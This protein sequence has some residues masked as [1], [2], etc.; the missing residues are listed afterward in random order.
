MQNAK[1]FG[2]LQRIRQAELLYIPLLT[3][4]PPPAAVTASSHARHLDRWPEPIGPDW[5]PGARG[6]IDRPCREKLPEVSRP[7]EL[8]CSSKASSD[9]I[10]PRTPEKAPL[11]PASGCMVAAPPWRR[12]NEIN[13]PVTLAQPTC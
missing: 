2:R 5:L 8:F 12:A 11:Q 3:H 10:V 7:S 4:H 13:S 9:Q 6:V 1:N